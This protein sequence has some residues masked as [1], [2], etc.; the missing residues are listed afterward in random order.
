MPLFS[1]KNLPAISLISFLAYLKGME[2]EEIEAWYADETLKKFEMYKEMLKAVSEKKAA[3]W[4]QEE[5]LKVRTKYLAE[6]DLFL[7]G[8]KSEP[9]LQRIA[10][11]FQG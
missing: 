7:K 9:I 6:Y 5:M 4:Y 10:L 2:E 8:G 1:F 3:Q 11:R